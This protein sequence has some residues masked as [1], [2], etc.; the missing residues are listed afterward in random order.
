[1]KYKVKAFIL[2]LSMFLAAATAIALR[3]THKIADEGPRIDLE[4]MIPQNFGDWSEDLQA[5]SLMVDPQQSA[6]VKKLYSQTLSRTYINSAG[7]RIMLSLAYGKDQSDGLQMHKPEVCYPAQGFQVQKKWDETLN[8]AHGK[9]HVRRIETTFGNNR[10]EPITYWSLVGNTV[11]LSEVSKKIVQIKYSFKGQIPDGLL[12]RVSSID[13][14]SKVAF[15]VQ[16]EFVNS[17]LTTVSP[18][19]RNNL[20]GL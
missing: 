1:M 6:L 11:A 4:K 14:D 7:Y 15:E 12:F 16:N 13:S 17:L 8:V 3:P 2:M 19:V 18:G 5:N 9:I 10:N 20:S